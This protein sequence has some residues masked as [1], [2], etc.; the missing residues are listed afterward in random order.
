MLNTCLMEGVAF[1]GLLRHS[2]GPATMPAEA[3]GELCVPGQGDGGRKF[4]NVVSK[5][6]VKAVAAYN[7][8]S[9]DMLGKKFNVLYKLCEQQLS[10]Q[11]HYRA[12]RSPG[13]LGYV[14]S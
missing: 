13:R 2:R 4:L 14:G 10:K 8:K 12:K 5:T 7:L 1:L 11:R 9:M 3:V 6:Q